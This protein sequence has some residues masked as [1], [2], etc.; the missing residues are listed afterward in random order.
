MDGVGDAQTWRDKGLLRW[1]P[2]VSLT[3]PH[4]PG[5]GGRYS[6]DP[7]TEEEVGS[8]RSRLTEWGNWAGALGLL[9]PCVLSPQTVLSGPVSSRLFSSPAHHSSWKQAATP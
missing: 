7:V 9:V 3:F 2:L 4:I 5:G 1:A 8:G 6:Y